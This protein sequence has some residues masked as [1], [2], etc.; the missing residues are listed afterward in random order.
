MKIF[1]L[2]LYTII[3]RKTFLIFA[4][5]MVFL[6]L[7]LPQLTPWEE[8]ANLVEPA[9]A[10]TAWTLLWLSAIVWLLLQGASLADSYSRSGVFRYLRTGFLGKIFALTQICASCLTVFVIFALIAL[11]VSFLGAMPGDQYEASQW[12]VLNFQYLVCLFL[13]VIPL[14]IVAVSLGTRL[15]AIVA[16]LIPA[17]LAFYGLVGITYLEFFMENTSNELLAI[18]YMI[19]PHYHFA[20]L[21]DRLV[22]KMGALP[23]STFANVCMYLVGVG[24]ILISISVPLFQEEK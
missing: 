2:C 9:R 21:T 1:K 14:L 8:K 5:L 23:L 4:A 11:G 22:F 10:Q 18:I 16:Y 24:F 3:C 12:V 20:D 7:L 13:T 6:S 19:S 17:G 15:N